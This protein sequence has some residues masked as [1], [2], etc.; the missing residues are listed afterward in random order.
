[1]AE[2][3]LGQPEHAAPFF[4]VRIGHVLTEGVDDPQ[5]GPL[6]RL[7]IPEPSRQRTIEAPVG[8]AAPRSGGLHQHVAGS[9]GQELPQDLEPVGMVDV[10]PQEPGLRDR[11]L[12]APRLVSGRDADRYWNIMPSLDVP[13]GK[14]I[15]MARQMAAVD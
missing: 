4:A 12:R 3:K 10:D 1:M 6:D 15:N 13:V 9:L 14:V 5:V 11:V 7:A 2:I 8:V